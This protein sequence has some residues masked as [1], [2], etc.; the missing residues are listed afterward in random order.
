MCP[1]ERVFLRPG[2]Q[3][4]K[5]KNLQHAFQK[6]FS[7]LHLLCAVYYPESSFYFEKT[8]VYPASSIDRGVL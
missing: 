8:L 2:W 1:S 4:S 7:H 5:A 3:V 6:G